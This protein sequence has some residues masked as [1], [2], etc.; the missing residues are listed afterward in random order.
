[1]AEV[2]H[3]AYRDHG[4]SWAVKTSGERCWGGGKERNQTDGLPTYRF[5]FPKKQLVAS[6]SE[7]ASFPPFDKLPPDLLLFKLAFDQRLAI[8]IYNCGG[9][10]TTRGLFLSS[11]C[12]SWKPGFCCDAEKLFCS[13]AVSAPRPHSSQPQALSCHFRKTFQ[14]LVIFAW[15]A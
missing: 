9:E 15:E 6:Q 13:L 2:S 11:L 4:Q 8:L 14:P 5:S 7:V 10:H 3:A 12:P 1:M